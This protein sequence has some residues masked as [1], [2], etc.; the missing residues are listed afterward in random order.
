MT[1]MG[2]VSTGLYDGTLWQAWS[3]EMPAVI[4]LPAAKK[5]PAAF[6]RKTG[7]TGKRKK[8]STGGRHQRRLAKP[9]RLQ[10]GPGGRP[11]SG[12]RGRPVLQDSRCQLV[13]ALTLIQTVSQGVLTAES[14]CYGYGL[15]R[16]WLLASKSLFL[17]V[18]DGHFPSPFDTGSKLTA[19]RS[20]IVSFMR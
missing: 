2:D 15:D 7:S 8:T 4:G 10:V 6:K 14:P 12:L 16:Y 9:R 18:A 20:R 11:G 3:V 5:S 19:S 13:P 1:M 17:A